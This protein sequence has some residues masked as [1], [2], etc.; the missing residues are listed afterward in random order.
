MQNDRDRL[1]NRTDLGR[2]TQLLEGNLYIVDQS[3]I[4]INEVKGTWAVGEP[5]GGRAGRRV[6]IF[7][8]AT[9]LDNNPA[10]PLS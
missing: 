5:Y 9:R 8:A 10:P 3:R 2:M 7:H 6:Q 1:L 4:R